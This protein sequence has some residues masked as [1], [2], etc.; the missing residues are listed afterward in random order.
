MTFT[1]PAS[2]IN[3]SVSPITSKGLPPRPYIAPDGLSNEDLF[4]LVQMSWKTE[5]AINDLVAP[6]SIRAFIC[7]PAMAS[8]ILFQHPLRSTT[9]GPLTESSWQQFLAA[10][11]G[12]RG[13]NVQAGDK[14]R[15]L[16]S[17]LESTDVGNCTARAV[18]CQVHWSCV[19]RAY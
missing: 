7:I 4:V 10:I 5:S 2:V 11:S 8:W 3:S 1:G 9:S 12:T 15:R 16:I 19:G 13:R 17:R 6:V 18:S 14:I